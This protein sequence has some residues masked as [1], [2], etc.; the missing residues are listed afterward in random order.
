MTKSVWICVKNA[1]VAS[2][3]YKW[4]EMGTYNTLVGLEMLDFGVSHLLDNSLRSNHRRCEYASE[5]VPCVFFRLLL[6][7]SKINDSDFYYLSEQINCLALCD[8]TIFSRRR[9]VNGK[10]LFTATKYGTAKETYKY[11]KFVCGLYSKPI[12]CT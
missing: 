6:L 7:F 2:K 5:Q 11:I 3:A 4:H 10:K 9:P 8:Q 1:N 12:N